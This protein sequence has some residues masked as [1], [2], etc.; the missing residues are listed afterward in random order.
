M[1]EPVLAKGTPIADGSDIS[2]ELVFEFFDGDRRI[3]LVLPM[4]S[5]REKIVVGDQCIIDERHWAT[6][7]D[8]QFEIEDDAYSLTLRVHS[9]ASAQMTCTLHKNGVLV[10]RKRATP[11]SKHRKG[12]LLIALVCGVGIVEAVRA[13]DLSA[14]LPGVLAVLWFSFFR[15]A[16]HRLKFDIRD[17]PPGAPTVSAQRIAALR[18]Q[19]PWHRTLQRL[20][21][22]LRAGLKLALCFRSGLRDVKPGASQLLALVLISFAIPVLTE[23]LVTDAPRV[24]FVWAAMYHASNNFVLFGAIFCVAHWLRVPARILWMSVALLAVS[25]WPSLI[26]TVLGYTLNEARYGEGGTK[27]LLIIAGFAVWASA[28]TLRVVQ[29]ASAQ[30]VRQLIVPLAV[31]LLVTVGTRFGLPHTAFWYTDEDSEQQH[32]TAPPPVDVEGIYTRQPKLLAASISKLPAQQTGVTDLYFVGF[33]S[34]ASQDVFMKEVN[35]VRERVQSHFAQ[36]THAIN[37]INNAQTVHDTPLATVSNLREVLAAIGQRIDLNDDV[38][39]LYLSSHGSR[40]GVLSVQYDGLNPNQLDARELRSMLDDSGI[41]WRIVVLSA[42]YSGSFIDALKTPYTLV[43]TAAREDRTSFGCSNDRELTYFAEHLFQQELS[44]ERSLL[45]SFERA[46]SS[47]TARES[48]EGHKASDPQRF[49]GEAM[50]TKISALEAQA[51]KGK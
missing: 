10:G 17:S 3:A 41:R 20:R 45:E 27:Y 1:T 24:F 34:Y 32:Y 43:L 12:L 15:R 40:G 42:C 7:S 38:L 46:H 49:V 21:R 19:P 35:F 36:P 48:L 2:N 16:K 28:Y 51:S 29:A 14:W 50:K 11:I 30:T 31:F 47:L 6:A 44:G 39:F 18:A 9:V 13:L 25:L 4:G 23:L 5:A 22:N 33:G 26:Q 8:H 37:L